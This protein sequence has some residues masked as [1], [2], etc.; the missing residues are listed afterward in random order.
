MRNTTRWD[1]LYSFVRDRKRDESKANLIGLTYYPI[2][3]CSHPIANPIQ[4]EILT[5][6]AFPI[7]FGEPQVSLYLNRIIHHDFS[8]NIQLIVDVKSGE[9]TDDWKLHKLQCGS[10][11]GELLSPSSVM[12]WDITAEFSYMITE[13]SD[14]VFVN[15]KSRSFVV[16]EIKKRYV[17]N[18]CPRCGY[19]PMTAFQYP[20]NTLD[21]LLTDRRFG[22]RCMN[23]GYEEYK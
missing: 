12:L 5:M 4:C 7:I 17:G 3:Y 16:F 1:T 6:G 13:P 22:F 11:I 10:E 9:K 18:Q 21:S 2:G 20:P 19:G 15:D 14:Y 8:F 23:C